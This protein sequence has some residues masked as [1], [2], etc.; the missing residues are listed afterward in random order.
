[1]NQHREVNPPAAAKSRGRN[2][3]RHP[4]LKPIHTLG[5]ATYGDELPDGENQ[6]LTALPRI[7]AI[8]QV[9]LSA[10]FDL[11]A[12]TRPND[13]TEAALPDAEPNDRSRLGQISTFVIIQTSSASCH[14]SEDPDASSIE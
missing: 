10:S 6:R 11:A 13:R 2:A 8:G 14:Q 9:G 3:V 7:S 12:V 5:T 4:D 1:V